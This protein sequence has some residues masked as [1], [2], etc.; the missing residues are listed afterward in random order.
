MR[1]TLIIAGGFALLL[2]MLAAGRAVGGGHRSALARS[3][4]VFLPIWL[5]AA[6]YNMWVGVRHAG[7]SVAEEAPILLIIFGLP[8]A[9]AL[10]AWRKFSAT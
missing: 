2:L 1:T 3:A 9:A 10:F 5:A 7:Y 6:S 4:L 8:A